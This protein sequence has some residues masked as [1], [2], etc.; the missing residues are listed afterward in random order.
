MSRIR[1]FI[2]FFR[3]LD[4]KVLLLLIVTLSSIAITTIIPILLVKHTDIYI[5]SIGTIKTIGVEAYWD[6]DNENKTETIDWGTIWIRTSKNMT[7]Y[8]RSVS[9]YEVTLKLNATNWIPARI[10]DYM[11]LSWDYN[12]M[13]INPGE[14]IQVTLILS[15]SFS[16]SFVNYL[17][18]NDVQ[19]F[20]FDIH[21]VAYE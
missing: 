17:I 16:G 13:S 21:I 8:I 18:I 12:G 10:A 15:T 4:K 3:S 6:R 9:N 2:D 19:S 1:S 11:T 20:S 7:L 5:P 14:I